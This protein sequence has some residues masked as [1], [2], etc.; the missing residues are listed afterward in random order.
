MSMFCGGLVQKRVGDYPASSGL[1]PVYPQ[2]Q[3]SLQQQSLLNTRPVSAGYSTRST[4]YTK[5]HY[6]V[7]QNVEAPQ[8]VVRARGPEMYYP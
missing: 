7:A 8:K 2:Q 1:S 6:D 3:S 4:G 5:K